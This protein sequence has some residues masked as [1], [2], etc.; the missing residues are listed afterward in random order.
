[1]LLEQMSKNLILLLDRVTTARDRSFYRYLRSGAIN[2]NL[3]NMY[4]KY[5]NTTSKFLSLPN[6]R[7]L[8]SAISNLATE[9]PIGTMSTVPIL[10][11]SLNF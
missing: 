10:N 7:Y 8:T 2:I 5:L 11:R 9:I 3:I 4:I 6:E 1:M